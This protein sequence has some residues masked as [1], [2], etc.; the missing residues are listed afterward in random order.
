MGGT[1]G[2]GKGE[3]REGDGERGEGGLCTYSQ[4]GAALC[5]LENQERM[6]S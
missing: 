2:K 6:L 4:P 3:E 5:W 1:E